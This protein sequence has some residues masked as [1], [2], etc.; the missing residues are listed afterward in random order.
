[1]IEFTSKEIQT[2]SKENSDKIEKK[3]K[4]G[5]K[6]DEKVEFSVELDKSGQELPTER[7]RESC[8]TQGK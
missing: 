2:F 4:E 6:V 3:E 1:M 5:Q 8:K 7:E